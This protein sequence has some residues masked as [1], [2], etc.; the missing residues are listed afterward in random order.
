MRVENPPLPLQG[1]IHLASPLKSKNY[2][3]GSD[4]RVVKQFQKMSDVKLM[5]ADRDKSK[6]FRLL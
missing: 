1:T 2:L 4:R 3:Q 5:Y 6:G